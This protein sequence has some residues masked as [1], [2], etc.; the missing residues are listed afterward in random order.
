MSLPLNRLINTNHHRFQLPRAS[1]IVARSAAFARSPLASKFARYESTSSDGKVQGAVIGIDLGTT[2]SAVA[3]MEGKVPRIIENSEGEFHL[4]IRSLDPP[5][6]STHQV[7]E[8]PPQLSLSPRMASDLSVS[9]PSVRPSSTQRTPS[10][11]PS[12]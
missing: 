6:T 5:L 11:L 10:S 3:I 12:D 1:P 2:N 8:L 9:L 4:S 7:P